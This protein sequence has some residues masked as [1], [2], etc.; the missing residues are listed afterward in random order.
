MHIRRCSACNMQAINSTLKIADIASCSFRPTAQQPR[1][2]FRRTCQSLPSKSGPEKLGHVVIHGF[3]FCVLAEDN[4]L[5]VDGGREGSWQTG[6]GPGVDMP[7]GGGREASVLL[8][9][10]SIGSAKRPGQH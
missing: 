4:G 5:S 8:T 7:V 1:R 9:T 3:P 10:A 6:F 2:H